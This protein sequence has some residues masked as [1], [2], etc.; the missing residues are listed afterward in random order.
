MIAS[1]HTCGDH[2]NKIIP[3][4]PKI[5]LFLLETQHAYSVGRV[6]CH[7]F[8]SAGESEKER[9]RW[10]FLGWA[11]SCR[12]VIISHFEHLS[13]WLHMHWPLNQVVFINFFFTLHIFGCLFFIR[14]VVV[15]TL[16]M[17]PLLL[18]FHMN[19]ANVLRPQCIH[20]IIFGSF[21]FLHR[22]FA[23]LNRCVFYTYINWVQLFIL[24][25]FSAKLFFLVHDF[26]TVILLLFFRNWTML[27]IH[28][29]M[30]AVL[31][32]KSS[33]VVCLFA[34]L[35]TSWIV[36]KLLKTILKQH[37]VEATNHKLIEW[38][39]ILCECE[40]PQKMHSLDGNKS[41]G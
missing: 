14:C 17:R 5:N 36:C 16:Y 23:N 30:L 1:L 4:R 29:Q 15:M 24:D 27:P 10:S 19:R 39:R 21:L 3:M 2:S 6:H 11:W 40:L 28:K 18:T 33:A 37:A 8:D 41:K 20:I 32:F 35:Q 9:E 26:Q 22:I 31:Y 12:A 25:A 7:C 34:L 13:C 38:K